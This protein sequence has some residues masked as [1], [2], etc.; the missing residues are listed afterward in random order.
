MEP[1]LDF[2]KRENINPLGFDRSF[3]GPG[4]APRAFLP[5]AIARS[6]FNSAK[7]VS[8]PFSRKIR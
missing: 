7:P 3:D 6:A 4:R 5:S 2:A 1:A 8:A